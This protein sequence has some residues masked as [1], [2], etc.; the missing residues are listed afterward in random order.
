MTMAIGTDL[1][2]ILASECGIETGL[3]LSNRR[4]HQHP[5]ES[6]EQPHLSPLIKI[7]AP[8]SD[9]APSGKSYHGTLRK[10]APSPASHGLLPYRIQNVT[11]RPWRQDHVPF[12]SA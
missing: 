1:E 5:H 12:A 8:K 10:Q 6:K 11:R 3:P 2:R 4:P 9:R 7:R